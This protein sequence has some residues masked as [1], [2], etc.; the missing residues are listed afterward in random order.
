MVPTCRATQLGHQQIVHLAMA[1]LESS[2]APDQEETRE[3]KRQVDWVPCRKVGLGELERNAAEALKKKH[4]AQDQLETEEGRY[5]VAANPVAQELKENL[6]YRKSKRKNVRYP[7][8]IF[9]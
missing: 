9:C 7:K 3:G 4:E 2:K 5:S 1:E 8:N 6:K